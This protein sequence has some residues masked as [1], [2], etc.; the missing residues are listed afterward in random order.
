[1]I[2]SLLILLFIFQLSAEEMIIGKEKI[3]PG[4]AITFEAAPRDTIHPKGL[5][6]GEAATDIHIE[7][8]ANWSADNP[9]DFPAGGFV[10]YLDAR[11]LIENQNNNKSLEINLSPHINLIDSLHYAKNL[12]LPGSISDKYDVT[13]FIE[14]NKNE[15]LGIHDDWH[16]IVGQ[17][18]SK[19]SFTYKNLSFEKIAKSVR[20]KKTL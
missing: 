1:M 4:I 3:K 5:H 7:M 2:R 18:V 13:F 19:H 16:N 9:Y 14:G 20:D 6:L 8:L 11:A 15:L 17:Y 12:K 10:A